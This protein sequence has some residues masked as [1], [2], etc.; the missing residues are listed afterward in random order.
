MSKQETVQKNSNAP[1]ETFRA[2]GVS[3][4]IWANEAEKDGKSFTVYNVNVERSYKKDD[5]W[6]KTSSMRVTDLPK[7]VLVANMAFKYLSLKK[8]ESE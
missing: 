3:A 8:D 6:V 5:E 4:T 2:G 1:V 7:V